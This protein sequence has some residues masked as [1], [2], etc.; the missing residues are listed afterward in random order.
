MPGLVSIPQNMLGTT[1][2]EFKIQRALIKLNRNFNFDWAVRLNIYAPNKVGKQ[3]I[4]FGKKHICSMDRGTIPQSQIWS[5]KKESKRLHTSEMT[6]AELTD[7]MLMREIEYGVDGT[8]RP[9]E[10]CF[11]MREVKDELLWIGWQTSLRKVLNHNFPGVTAETLGREL[12]VTIDVLKEGMQENLVAEN[13]T[14]LYTASGRRI[15]V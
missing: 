5:T 8:E 4:F 9:T 7:P 10:Y 14:H 6:Y 13:R 12:G 11:V 15:E 1:L 2:H 3:G